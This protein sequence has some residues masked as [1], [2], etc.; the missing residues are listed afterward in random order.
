MNPIEAIFSF[1]H[2]GFFTRRE[3]NAKLDAIK[4]RGDWQ[5]GGHWLGFDYQNQQWVKY[6]SGR[7]SIGSASQVA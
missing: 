5:P 3:L 2:D 6:A 1:Y 7:V 4:V